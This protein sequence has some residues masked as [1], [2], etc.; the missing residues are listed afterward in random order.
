MNVLD[1]GHPDDMPCSTDTCGFTPCHRD[2][3]GEYVRDDDP[4]EGL[5][6]GPVLC[7]CEW[8]EP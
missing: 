6:A 5:P 4:P 7:R 2:D 8:H 1:H 3:D